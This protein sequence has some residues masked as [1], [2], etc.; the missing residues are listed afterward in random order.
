MFQ[1]RLQIIDEPIPVRAPIWV[2]VLERHRAV[3]VWN[4]LMGHRDPA[5]AKE[6]SPNSLRAIYGLNVHENAVAGPPDNETAESQIAALF[7]SSPPFGPVDS[8]Q[9]SI[10][11]VASELLLQLREVAGGEGGAGSGS[12]ESYARSAASTAGKVQARKSQNG[13]QNGSGTFKAR[14]LPSTTRNPESQPRM[15]KA[16]ALRAGVPL[17][18]LARTP[19]G[20]GTLA[21]KKNFD[22]VPGH[23]R[24]EAIKVASTATPVIVPR[25]TKAAEL[26]MGITA[27]KPR[28]GPI[29]K[30]NGAKAK[31][32]N[33]KGTN[34]K[35]TTTSDAAKATF[36]G[37]PGHKR[38][39]SISVMSTKEP[40][41]A[42]R[43][44]RSALLRQQKEGAPPSS[45]MCMCQFSPCI[46]PSLTMGP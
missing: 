33:A 43:I 25:L 28:P 45:Y 41:V 5:I 4:T 38:R 26:R 30:E 9:N 21:G 18:A 44:N 3:E 11:S 36:E 8:R 39:E 27:P 7:A 31:A 6:T 40:T 19:S 42:P 20:S 16:A 23:K 24:T 46:V 32:A 1:I 15:T 34:G 22:N 37:V 14:A 35:S 13:N 17:T 10:R 29:L 12:E 2:Y